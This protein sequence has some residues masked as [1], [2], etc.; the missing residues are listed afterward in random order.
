V[1]TIDLERCDGCGAC[2]PVC[3]ESAIYLVDSKAAVHDSLCRDCEACIT[4][5]PT[6]AI[7]LVSQDSMAQPSREMALRPEPQVIRVESQP[8]LVPLRAKAL[9]VLGAVLVWAG[10]EIVPRLASAFLD[11]LDLWATN[12]G[13]SPV[14]QGTSSSGSV[15]RPNEGGRGDQH[16]RRQRRRGG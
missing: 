16:R 14:V 15:V 1:I 2:L 5:C 6:E 11:G 3:S 9:P 7:A 10:R 4:A 13:A 8:A 12:R